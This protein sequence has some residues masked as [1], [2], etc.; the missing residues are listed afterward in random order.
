MPSPCITTHR[1]Y[2]AMRDT[3]AATEVRIIGFLS[4]YGLSMRGEAVTELIKLISDRGKRCRRSRMIGEK[5][6]QAFWQDITTQNSLAWSSYFCDNAA[7]C[8]H[9]TNEKFTEDEYIRANCDYRERQGEKEGA[10]Q[11][12]SKIIIAGKVQSS[13]NTISCNNFL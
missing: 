6:I 13:E 8:W 1:S 3:K 4:P 5:W 2:F 11:F 9:C 10:E 7:I 12:D